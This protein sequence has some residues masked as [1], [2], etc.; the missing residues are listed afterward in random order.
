M[1]FLR[2]VHS[3]WQSNPEK[4][5]IYEEEFCLITSA[6]LSTLVKMARRRVFGVKTKANLG[7]QL[8]RLAILGE[9]PPLT[10][11]TLIPLLRWS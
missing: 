8:L 9:P 1:L 7:H 11:V 4:G 10:C 2:T 5:V 3:F 6:S